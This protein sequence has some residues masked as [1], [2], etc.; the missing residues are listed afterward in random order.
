METNFKHIRLDKLTD[1]ELRPTIIILMNALESAL[2]TIDELRAEIKDLKDEIKFLKGEQGQPNFNPKKNPTN[3]SS[4]KFHN[5]SKRTRRILSRDVK[6]SE[7]HIKIDQTVHCELDKSQLPSDII[8]KGV[9]ITI[10]Q[11]IIFRSN[12]TRYIRE[13]YYSPS[14]NKTYTAPLPEDCTGYISDKIKTFCHIFHHDLDLSQSKIISALRPIGIDLTTGMLN[15]ILIEPAEIVINEKNRIL[16]AGLQG[17]FTQIDGTGAKFHGKSYTT[18]MICSDD[19]TIF[20]TLAKKNRLH[21]LYAL[22]GEPQQGLLYRYNDEAEKYLL[23]FK[24]SR[25]DIAILKN[26]FPKD[27]TLTE[28]EF[29]NIMSKEYPAVYAKPN[30]FFRMCESLAFG[31]YFTQTE[32]ST[33][34]YLVSDDAPEYNL[35]SQEHMLCWVHDARYYNKLSPRLEN[36]RKTLADFLSIYWEFYRLLQGYKLQPSPDAALTLEAKFDEVFQPKTEYFD[37]NKEIERTKNNKS[38]LLTVLK[39]PLL[40]LHNNLAEL[41][42]RV[43]VRKRDISLHT[44]SEIGT[45]IQDAMMSITQT[46]KQNGVDL[47]KYLSDLINQKNDFSLADLIYEKQ[48][49]S[50]P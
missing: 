19:F 16:K 25:S 23:H 37:L 9:E 40:P 12:N 32:Y 2:K 24:V 7:N 50:T 10:R 8:N 1:S 49:N 30:M 34:K 39:Q 11:D 17:V 22:L 31:Y 13:K 42:A 26:R 29:L 48:N 4:E 28:L 45:K 14:L 43:Q 6:I 36:N 5:E 38:E 27:Q 35:L 18:Q 46:A 33:I 20:A 21:L 3:I 41:K 15:N 47:W 44:M